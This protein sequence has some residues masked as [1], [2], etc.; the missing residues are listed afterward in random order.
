MHHAISDPSRIPSFRVGIPALILLFSSLLLSAAGLAADS[1]GVVKFT[2]GDVTIES[3]EGETRNAATDDDLMPGEL[4]VTGAASLA[5]I[6]LNDDTR[7]T[8]RPGSEFRVNRLDMDDDSDGSGQIA[9]LNLLR[10]GLRL[11]TGLVGRLNPA[12]FRLGTPVATIGIRGTEFDTRI[13]GA[14][15]AAEEQV[16]A[17]SDA[18]AA[19]NEGLYVSVDDG[20]VFVENFSAGEPLE[21]GAGESGYV[22][23]LYSLPVKLSLVP[24]FQSLD[25][26]PSPGEL[27]FDD[28]E[29]PDDALQVNGS[30]AQVGAVA[31]AAA[32]SA[33]AATASEAEAAGLDIAGTYEIEDLSYGSQLPLADRRWFF[34]ANPDIEFTLT[35]E[36]DN[37]EGE[38]EG[39]RDGTIKGKID[40]EKVTFE[41]VL[42]AKGGEYKDGAGTWIVQGDGSLDGDFNIEDRQRGVIRGLWTLEKTD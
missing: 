37:F 7:M 19:I 40:G 42:E 14:D 4:I 23:D 18:A 36:G 1:V 28:I 39:D 30:A 11:V 17:D 2:R 31:A 34:G 5:V 32:A 8:L 12:G 26:I 38:F 25:R 35:Q 24:A 10:G 29:I 21:L 27:D 9:V 16:L 6:Q 13:C 22:A 3:A 33:A 41:F 20:Q 15:C